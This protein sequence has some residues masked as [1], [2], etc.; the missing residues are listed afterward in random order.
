MQVNIC[1]D[2][3]RHNGQVT[4]L[5]PVICNITLFTKNIEVFGI[6]V[7]PV[8]VTPLVDIMWFAYP[9]AGCGAGRVIRWMLECT[10]QCLT[11]YIKND[12]FP[13]APIPKRLERYDDGGIRPGI[14]SVSYHQCF[15]G[16]I[17]PENAYRAIRL[18]KR[19]Y[20]IKRRRVPN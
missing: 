13:L 17:L 1:G 10:P 19:V 18:V 5:L 2:H 4:C 9:T 20:T 7:A 15:H 12:L 3:Y 11:T 16:Q 8:C 6:G 14:G